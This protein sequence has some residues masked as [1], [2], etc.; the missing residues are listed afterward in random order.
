[1]FFKKANNDYLASRP[2]MNLTRITTHFFR[3]C[4]FAQ[5]KQEMPFGIA[6]LSRDISPAVLSPIKINDVHYAK[7]S[8]VSSWLYWNGMNHGTV[9]IHR[10]SY[11][12]RLQV[13]PCGRRNLS[14]IWKKNFSFGIEAPYAK[15]KIG[16]DVL[17]A[18]V[19][20]PLPFLK[21]LYFWFRF[22]CITVRC[23]FSY[24]KYSKTKKSVKDVKITN[25][26]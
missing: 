11:S 8:V 15:Q 20:F 16:C 25:W 22:Q 7:P 21:Q 3:D 24:H 10:P 1:M 13:E 23:L 6:A 5:K 4:L 18:A 12:V 19:F 2:V 26:F 9:S 14:L 17:Q